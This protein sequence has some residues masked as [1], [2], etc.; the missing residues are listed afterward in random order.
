MTTATA[1]AAAASSYK[2][3]PIRQPYISNALDVAGR[4]G[5]AAIFLISG[6]S[7]LGQ[8][9]GTQGYMEAMGVPGAL[10]PLVIAVEVLGGAAIL[11]GAYTRWAAFVLAGF[12]VVSALIFHADFADQVQGIMF[13]KNIAIAGGFL[14]Y[15]VHGT[16]AWSVDR[17]L[18][19]V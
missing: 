17:Q 6:L 14:G 4:A 15:L 8:Y 1:A 12:S 11:A 13:W 5:L 3:R 9:A 10:L 16:G 7:K 18:R 19:K 2:N